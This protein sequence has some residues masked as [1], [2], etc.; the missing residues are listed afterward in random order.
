M[1]LLG[2]FLIGVVIWRRLAPHPGK[3]ADPV[4]ARGRRRLRVGIRLCWGRSGP[5]TAPFF[6]SYGLS[7]AA[8]IGT[9]AA[10]ALTMHLTKIAAYGAGD[11]LTGTVVV[12]A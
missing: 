5:L 7:C 8:Y 1:R 10:S 3:P 6:L 11:L 12:A 4:F 9:E 2:V